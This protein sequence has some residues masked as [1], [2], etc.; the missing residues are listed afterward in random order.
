MCLILN[1]SRSGTHLSTPLV[2]CPSRC[3]VA[4]PP[5]PEPHRI[6]LNFPEMSHAFYGFFGLLSVVSSCW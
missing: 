6:V 2:P 4:D 5:S 1:I 3:L